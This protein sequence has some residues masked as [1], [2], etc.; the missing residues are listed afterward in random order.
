M[1][2]ILFSK[3]GNALFLI[4]IAVALFA[5]LSYAVTQSSRGG[6]SI[7]REQAELIS[8]R[9]SSFYG[10]IQ[11]AITRMMVINGCTDIQ[12]SFENSVYYQGTG[13]GGGLAHPID[14]NGNA[15]TDNRC[16]V[17]ETAGG[18]V[19]PLVLTQG[20][21]SPDPWNW[22]VPG[23]LWVVTEAVPGVGTA[24]ADLVLGIPS[25][26]DEVCTA[27]NRANGY[28]GSIITGVD[29]YNN[30]Y[31]GTYAPGGANGTENLFPS[32]TTGICTRY[33]VEE[34]NSLMYV[35]LAR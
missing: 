9:V 4:L 26:S 23:H 16:S 1:K 19:S 20:L 11:H 10:A 14:G 8:A 2:N 30:T 5:A 15:P 18:G 6:G 7:D 25:I 34:T 22:T 28:T 35:V 33:T 29:W 21:T 24:A 17:F 32:G 12:I 31:N 27:W 3:R 13:A